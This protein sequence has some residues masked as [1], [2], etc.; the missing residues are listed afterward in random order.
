MAF[1]IR[2]HVNGLKCHS[3]YQASVNHTAGPPRDG[4]QE[5][6]HLALSGIATMIVH[7]GR[8][9]LQY[10]WLQTAVW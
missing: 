8:D 9:P 1:T 2:G 3:H 4:I 7:I 5:E 6:E 10:G